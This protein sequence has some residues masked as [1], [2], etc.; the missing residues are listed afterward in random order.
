MRDAAKKVNAATLVQAGV[1]QRATRQVVAAA[2]PWTPNAN[3][4]A[5]IAGRFYSEELETFW[6][7]AL[8]EGTLVVR[9]RRMTDVPLRATTKDTFTGGSVTLTLERDRAGQ[10]IGFYANVA[11]SRDI[12]FER[13][14]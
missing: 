9:Q 3:E 7:F 4:L 10:V 8:V 6:Q 2:A 13:Q 1:R 5:A 11:R 12:R 14:R